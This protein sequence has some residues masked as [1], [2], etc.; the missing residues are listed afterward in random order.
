MEKLIHLSINNSS[1]CLLLNVFLYASILLFDICDK[2]L[3]KNINLNEFINEFIFE[4]LYSILFKLLIN[5]V[6]EIS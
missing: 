2:Y 5:N 1:I 3:F 4:L 6:F